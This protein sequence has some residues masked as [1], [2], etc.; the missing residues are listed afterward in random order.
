MSPK[1]FAMALLLMLSLPSGGC[2]RRP[3]CPA[4]PRP[5]A[6]APEV[7]PAPRP[8]CNLPPLPQPVVFGG[9]PDGEHVV[10]TRSGLADLSRWMVLTDAWILA[11]ATCLDVQP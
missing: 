5:I 8:P 1:S 3:S 6:P 10:I 7:V 11:A 9:I 2:L 4:L